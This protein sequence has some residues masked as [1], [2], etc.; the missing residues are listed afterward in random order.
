MIIIFKRN[1]LKLI[2]LH[3]ININNKDIKFYLSS[4]S[5][6]KNINGFII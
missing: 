4:N 3:N 5:W 2:L 1:L 6:I